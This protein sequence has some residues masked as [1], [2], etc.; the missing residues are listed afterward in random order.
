VWSIIHGNDEDLKVIPVQ[1]I[2]NVVAVIPYPGQVNSDS[3]YK[4]CYVVE[5][6]GMDV[7]EFGGGEVD[8]EPVQDN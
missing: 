8:Q 7:W 6:P 1:Y 5:K 2:R 4:R 3:L